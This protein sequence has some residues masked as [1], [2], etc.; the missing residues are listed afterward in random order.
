MCFGGWLYFSLQ[1]KWTYSELLKY[2]IIIIIITII[3]RGSVVG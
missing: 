3:L 2:I 1:D